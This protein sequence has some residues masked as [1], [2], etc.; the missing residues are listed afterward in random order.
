MKMEAPYSQTTIDKQFI[1]GFPASNTGGRARPR[2]R[3]LANATMTVGRLLAIALLVCIAGCQQGGP[4]NG[5][6]LSNDNN[7]PS[8]DNGS[9]FNDNNSPSDNSDGGDDDGPDDVVFDANPTLSP[10]P[11]NQSPPTLPAGSLKVVTLGDSVTEGVGDVSGEGGGFPRRLLSEVERVRPGTTLLNVGHS[12]WTSSE[13]I[14]GL[15]DPPSEL[16]Q[17]VAVDPD[18][19]TVWIGSN[20]L[21]QLYEY[22]P[23]TGTPRDL[24][25]DDLATF[26]ENIETI[27]SRLDATGA[28]IYVGLLDDQSLRPVA[29]D[30]LTLPN[31][32]SA[33]LTQMSAQVIRYNNVLIA[34]SAR[35]GATVVD[36]YHTTIFTDAAT[37]DPDGIHPNPTGYDKVAEGWLAAIEQALN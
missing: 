24:E 37:L 13:L 23:E 33:E 25:E 20:D 22:G 29:S 28:A 3:G 2:R 34:A 4:A 17:A 30:R 14:A 26:A 11:V 18:I 27:L 10:I 7:S 35:H 8:N 32:T 5:G 16:D 1:A 15:G 12:G 36:F 19:A 6:G 21:W 9:P 31:T